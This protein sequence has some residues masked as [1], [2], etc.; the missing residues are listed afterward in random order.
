MSEYVV[1]VHREICQP[2]SQ[3][4]RER[5]VPWDNTLALTLVVIGGRGRETERPEKNCNKMKSYGPAPP[6]CK[7]PAMSR[8]NGEVEQR[9]MF[10]NVTHTSFQWT[11]QLFCWM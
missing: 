6:N 5:E 2:T 11:F 1:I 9:I 3:P 4:N 7:V 10:Y 8:S